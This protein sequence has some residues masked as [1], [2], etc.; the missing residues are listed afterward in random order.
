VV[1]A[2]R[3]R[4][5]LLILDQAE[6][7]NARVLQTIR[8]CWDRCRLDG[9]GVVLLG[10]PLL[11]ERMRDGRMKDIGALTSRVGIWAALRGVQ[12]AEMIDI[13]KKE[14]ITDI[15]DEA[16]RLLCQATAGSMR[17]LLAVVDLLT[18]KH[19]ARP[20]TACTIETVASHLFGLD[21]GRAI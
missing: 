3:E 2:L 5:A 16:F 12:R 20:I 1:E 7:A 17:R 6:T 19:T 11:V 15:S 14:G 4:P 13:L 21:I 9:V 18:A 10:S 8:Q